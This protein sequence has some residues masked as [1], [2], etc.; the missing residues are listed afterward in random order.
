MTGLRDINDFGRVEAE[1]DSVLD[2][3]VEMNIAHNIEESDSFM[4]IGRK[5]TGKTALFRFFTE[6]KHENCSSALNLSGYPWKVHEGFKD[7]G[8]EDVESYVASWKYLIAIELSKNILNQ[9]EDYH[10][11]EVME[12]DRFFKDNYGSINPT[13]KD[14]FAP[15]TITISG[16][17]EPQ[18]LG[19]KLGKISFSKVNRL[20][21]GS[22]ITALTDRIFEYILKISMHSYLPPTYLHFDELDRGITTLTESRKDMITG[23]I[24][25][26]KDVQNKFFKKDSPKFKSIVY[27]RKDIWDDLDFSDKNKI[28]MSNLELIEWGYDSLY[29][30]ID[31]RI[32]TLLGSA[33]EW[34]KLDDG[35]KINKQPKWKHI[36]DRSFLR[37]RDI[38]SFLNILISVCKARD[39]GKGTLV[40]ENKDIV[41]SRTKY[42]NYLKSELDDEIKPH[43]HKWEDSLQTLSKLGRIYFILDDYKSAYQEVIA[44]RGDKSLSAEE[45]LE[46]LYNFG[47]VAYEHRSGYGGSSWTS[48]YSNT[49]SS[50]DINANKFKVHLGLKEFL[51]LKEERS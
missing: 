12:L 34:D 42:S 46:Q 39:D 3:F 24:I 38:I 22:E 28:T 41:D 5:G 16:D 40:F 50:W 17:L 32:K 49:E 37:P 10:L 29:K 26:S 21:F 43:W 9:S 6:K 25:A 36:I 45:S 20:K 11:K 1:A 51:K 7:K 15:E 47:V 8:V 48:N 27:L 35:K 14:V 44:L 13:I 33:S 30:L 4:V 23:L 19:C 31:K 18:I 2:Y